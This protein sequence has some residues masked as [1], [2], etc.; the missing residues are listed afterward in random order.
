MIKKYGLPFCG[1]ISLWFQNIFNL[2][3]LITFM[4]QFSCD[5]CAQIIIYIFLSLI[6]ISR[7]GLWSFDLV[8]VQVIQEMVDDA[9]RGIVSG[10]EY[11]LTN[12]AYLALLG[13]GIIF[14]EPHQFIFIVVI[15]YGF[16]LL[17]S[18]VYSS[19]FRIQNNTQKYV[20]ISNEDVK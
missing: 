7:L 14:N 18:V 13:L 15:S 19:W 10:V 9:N 8:Q 12:L 3:A 20:H 5:S 4:L 2:F 17:S 16:L 6:I 1:V 11:S